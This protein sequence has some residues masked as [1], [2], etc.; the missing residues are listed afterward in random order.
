MA[1]S[2]SMLLVGWQEGRPACK[3]LSGGVLAW[4]SVWSEVQTCIWS[5]WCHCHLLSLAS[6]KCRL[7]LPFWY[8]LT[9]VVPD[10]SPL[11][12]VCVCQIALNGVKCA[13]GCLYAEK[14]LIHLAASVRCRLIKAGPQRQRIS[15]YA[16]AQ[17][18]KSSL[19]LNWFIIFFSKI[20]TWSGSVL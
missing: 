8:R 6:V 3:K 11:N 12:G 18:N 17:C 5:S 10:K 7:G 4:L 1:F 15:H 20:C 2:A 14:L 16:M 19:L 9:R 13:K